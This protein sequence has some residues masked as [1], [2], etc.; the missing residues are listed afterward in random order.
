MKNTRQT[1]ES[2]T[3]LEITP[4]GF[5]IYDDQ[6][7]VGL[8]N[9]TL[10]MELNGEDQ[11]VWYDSAERDEHGVTG[12]GYLGNT[13]IAC[14]TRL[15]FVNNGTAAT[16]QHRLKNEEDGTVTHI[17]HARTCQQMDE[18]RCVWLPF[19]RPHDLRYC[20][21]DNVRTEQYPYC[22]TESPYVRSLPVQ[23]KLCGTGQDQPFPAIYFTNRDYEHGIVVAALE[24]NHN[25]QSYRLSRTPTPDKSILDTFEIR[26]EFPLARGLTL[27]LNEVLEL[28]GLYVEIC[29]NTHPQDAYLNYVDHLAETHNFRG[30]TT[31]LRDEAL[32]CTW[33]YGRAARQVEEELLTTAEF[34]SDNMPNITF[35]LVD[36][37][38]TFREVDRSGLSTND[39][40]DVMYNGPDEML[41]PKK[42]ADMRAFTS[43]LRDMGLRPG[44][45]WTPTAMLD[46]NLYRDH[47]DWF[48]RTENGAPY[49]IAG[50]KGFLDLTVP[51][52][53]DFMDETL[54]II[55]GEWDIDATKM[56]FW[57]QCFEDR[58]ARHQRPNMTAVE[59]RR[60][61]FDLVR[62][63]LPDD[64][65]FMTC[66]ATGMG[67]PF[68]AEHA[69]TY[70]N[71]MDIG[72]GTWKHQIGS[73]YWALPAL[74]IPGRKT[75]LHNNDSVGIN[76]N[77]PENENFFRLTWGFITMGMQEIGGALEQLPEKYRRAMRKYTDRCDRGYRCQCPDERAFTG[78]P[79][80]E[81]LFVTYPED[82]R[83]RQNG[84]Q[85]S[86]ALFNWSEEPKVISVK[87]F[88]LGHK[89]PVEAENFW[90][91]EHETFNGEF[92]T[93]RLNPRSAK[94]YDVF[95]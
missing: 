21:T 27:D 64:G 26:H 70:R 30:P 56:D 50:R 84:V 78:E 5:G 3:T 31:K 6:R 1:S 83:T 33:N 60:I 19:S 23:E 95:L 59:T 81:S 57:S 14:E 71:T 74:G 43:K 47:S 94:L 72:S 38:Y 69:D 15:Y 4:G 63:Y 9:M 62:K 65:V 85:Q 25:Y 17:T 39:S 29:Q 75:F 46:S 68:I 54:S 86:L 45:W 40:L 92:I 82:S 91:E 22:M 61:L 87:R 49:R 35:F 76:L 16:I 79:L 28:D 18:D 77:C 93:K 10:A 51:D 55:L 32:Y 66:V 52:A 53:R 34:I 90:T 41:N 89:G 8:W 36:A 20:H 48:L 11:Q 2:G 80:P 24:E 12:Q 58:Q 67:K 88:G 73:C 42:I 13:D 44:L 7:E 37:G